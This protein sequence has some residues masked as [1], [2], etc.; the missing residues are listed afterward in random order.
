MDIEGWRQNIDDVDRQLVRLINERAQ[1]AQAI[2]RL[3]RDSAMP[4]YEPDRERTVFANV[5]EANP[6]PLA[7]RDLVRRVTVRCMA[8]GGGTRV[9]VWR[10]PAGKPV[11]QTAWCPHLGA[12]LSLG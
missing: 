7:G 11:V 9:V 2:G 8:E 5:Q 12:D 4:I 10:D 1:C 3:K 6:G